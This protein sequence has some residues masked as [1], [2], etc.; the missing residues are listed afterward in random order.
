MIVGVICI[1]DYA[2]PMYVSRDIKDIFLKVEKAIDIVAVVGARQ[3]GK[4]TFLKQHMK[5]RKSSYLLFDDPD[6]R[7]LFDEDVKSFELQY[8][9]GNELTVLDEVQC[10]TDA[11]SKLKYLAD[12]GHRLWITSSSEV[13]L[14]EEILSYLVG[15]VSTLRL[16][17]FSLS[18][19]LRSKGTVA[20]TERVL[21]RS[22]WEHLV[23]GGYPKMVLEKDIEV[24]SILLRDLY[25]TMILKD[26]VRNFSIADQTSLERL[27]KLLALNCGSVV[28]YNSICSDLNL[29]FQT[30]I[31]YIDALKKSYLIFEV[32]PYFTNKTKE[33]VKQPKIYFIDTGLRNAV[34]N[35]FDESFDG[36]SFENYVLSELLKIGMMPKFWRTK[37]KSEVDFVLEFGSDVVP[38]EVKVSSG[39]K[40]IERSLRSFIDYYH[41]SNAIVVGYKIV[42]GTKMVNGCKVHFVDVV[43]LLELAAKWKR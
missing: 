6:I 12:T 38:V 10:C 18:E 9:A 7:E 32:T 8:I 11:G 29:S 21:A 30:V 42:K 40:R 37:S 36:C 41:P 28:S 13:I 4:T 25:D 24:K 19:F 22:I 5:D 15:R 14:S 34:L 27:V 2:I 16:Y 26:V 31:K 3:S 35:R 43:D 23:Y 20:P 17:P 33:I 1:V 39:E